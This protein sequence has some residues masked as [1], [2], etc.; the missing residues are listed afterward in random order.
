MS[1]WEFF[2]WLVKSV[3]E[4]V[5]LIFFI[6]ISFFKQ[7]QIEFGI[8]IGIFYS[9]I[10]GMKSKRKPVDVARIIDHRIPDISN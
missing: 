5:T 7:L 10:K 9:K 1:Y 3:A 4:I 2:S 6:N 8:V